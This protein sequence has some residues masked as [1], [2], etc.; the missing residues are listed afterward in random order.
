MPSPLADRPYSLRHAAVSLWL[1]AGVPVTEVASE[2]ATE[3]MYS[4]GSMRSAS[5]AVRNVGSGRRSLA[6]GR[7]AGWLV[8]HG[9]RAIDLVL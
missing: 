6:L 3:S 1:N 9:M 4:C 2:L 8:C 5:M 7:T